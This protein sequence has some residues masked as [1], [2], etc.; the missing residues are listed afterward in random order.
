MF[1]FIQIAKREA[2][3]M[4]TVT[5]WGLW[6]SRDQPTICCHPTSP[7]QRGN[8][9]GGPP[10]QGRPD[11]WPRLGGTAAVQKTDPGHACR[12]QLCPSATWEGLVSLL[13]TPGTQSPGLTRCG[14]VVAEGRR[15]PGPQSSRGRV[16]VY[17]RRLGTSLLIPGDG[18]D[19]A[20]CPPHI[21]IPSGDP[22]TFTPRTGASA[23]ADL[24]SPQQGQWRQRGHQAPQP[25]SC[26]QSTK[27]AGPAWAKGQGWERPSRPQQGGLVQGSEGSQ[28]V[29]EGPHRSSFERQ[30]EMGFSVVTG[31][32]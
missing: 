20:Q 22:G 1:N 18:Q 14:W 32:R 16:G 25:V 24:A 28:Q 21:R 5:E 12:L 23:V 7:S 26:A 27:A 15:R 11:L 3:D 10:L 4:Y 29:P 31:A 8:T 30:Q 9:A 19:V 6:T 17:P 2:T 13:S